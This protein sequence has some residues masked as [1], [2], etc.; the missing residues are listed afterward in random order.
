MLQVEEKED[1][2]PVCPHCNKELKN[3]WC[4]II[5]SVF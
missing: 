4:R 3:I 2:Y 5:E 1:V